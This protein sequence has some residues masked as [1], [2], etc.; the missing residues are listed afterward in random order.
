MFHRPLRR[1]V[2]RHKKECTEADTK[3]EIA[4]M[5][6]QDGTYLSIDEA[7]KLLKVPRTT[8]CRRMKGG[9]SRKEAREKTQL[10]TCQEEKAL[11][12]WISKAT[13]AGNPVTQLIIHLRNG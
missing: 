12:D 8:L 9:K 2:R 7:V 10:L 4:V 3:M 11:A 6:V 1:L 5:G 13:V